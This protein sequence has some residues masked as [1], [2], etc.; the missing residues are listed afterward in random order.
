MQNTVSGQ[1]SVQV[2]RRASSAV[3]IGLTSIMLAA[4]GG[5]GGGG[6][7][8]TSTTAGTGT[9]TPRV[10]ASGF[11]PTAPSPVETLYSDAATLRPMR[12]EALWV[13]RG[14]RTQGSSKTV[15]AA[16]RQTVAELSGFSERFSSPLEGASEVRTLSTANGVV[17]LQSGMG[18]PTGVRAGSVVELRSPVRRDDQVT[19]L[20]QAG[21]ALAEDLDNDKKT[22]TIDVGAWSRVIG[23]EDIDLPEM[24]KTMRA[25]RVDVTVVS[26]VQMSSK[27]TP[28]ATKTVVE[29][30]WYA[31]DLGVIRR[32]TSTTTSTGTTNVQ[33]D[34]RLQYWDGVDRGI[35]LVPSV[36]IA[37]SGGS[38]GVGP[39]LSMP[40]SA[41]RSGKQA[42]LLSQRSTGATGVTLS[43][44]D[45][46]GRVVATVDHSDIDV[47]S[48]PQTDLMPLG[49]GV[50]MVFK[51]AGVY[52]DPYQ[53]ENLRLVRFDAQ[54]QRVG[55]AWLVDGAVPGTLK[56]ASDGSTV[57]VSWV[58][59]TLALD[60]LKV[61]VQAFD[62]SGRS[63]TSPLQLDRRAGLNTPDGMAIAAANG[64][65][66][67]S[68]RQ[69]SSTGDEY[70]QALVTRDPSQAVATLE[71]GA[72]G[73]ADSR[74]RPTPRLSDKL[75]VLTWYAPLNQPA[76][77]TSSSATARGV[78]LDAK[79]QPRRA[80]GGG[81]DNESLQLP[82]W[83]SQQSALQVDGDR[84]LW[85][86]A[87]AARL[88]AEEISNDRYLDL[89]A[90]TPDAAPL[91][92]AKPTLQR[93]RDRS[94]ANSYYGNV[95]AVKQI[96]SFDDRWLIVGQDGSNTTVAV[97]FRR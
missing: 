90:L 69:P 73:P 36:P 84:L 85:S 22:D 71:A 89:A 50:G 34:E 28:E 51:E 64:R 59:Q 38:P 6:E 68:W 23:N 45:L 86:S 33:T 10:T 61:M 52:L 16:F 55:S 74:G 4:C 12:D 11:V 91:A 83:P 92:A 93:W 43:V 30:T 58:E 82:A 27:A 76:G 87:G 97:L 96:L 20:D 40:V 7:A 95:T 9:S 8:G 94:P 14:V 41:V 88:S 53:L 5:G 25:L 75:A 67:V 39:W 1:H 15:Y 2:F 54:G 3:V 81:A 60:G 13:Y 35:G 63:L 31:P 70:R 66:L 57:W 79:A 26:R 29:S 32:S 80:A 21:I 65:A 48:L 62:A 77:V 18:L 78:V 24:G 19:L 17:M 42:F 46:R 56:A 49:D 47:A 44:L 72:V 37:V